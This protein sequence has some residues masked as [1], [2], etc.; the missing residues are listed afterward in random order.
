MYKQATTK[1]LYVGVKW[2]SCKKKKRLYDIQ[3]HISS[4]IF[5]FFLSFFSVFLKKKKKNG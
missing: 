4:L 5:F 2:N 1:S 3:F